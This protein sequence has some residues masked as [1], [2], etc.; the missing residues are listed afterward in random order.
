V[1]VKFRAAAKNRLL[2]IW[3]FTA[4]TWGESQAD[5]YIRGLVAAIR[6]AAN[7]RNRWRPI[8]DVFLPGIYVIRYQQHFIFFRALSGNMIGVISILHVRMNIPLRLKE[9]IE[10]DAEN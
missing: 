2:E 3:D 6:A 1:E 7:A 8:M 4:R 9:D 10:K 5:E